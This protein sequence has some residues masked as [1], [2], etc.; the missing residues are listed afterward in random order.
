MFEIKFTTLPDND[1]ILHDLSFYIS[2]NQTNSRICF[3]R[4]LFNKVSKILLEEFN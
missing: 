1:R 4:R 3:M 2:F